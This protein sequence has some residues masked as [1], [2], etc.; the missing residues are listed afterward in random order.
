MARLV[1]HAASP[2]AA[3]PDMPSRNIPRRVADNL[4]FTG[5]EEWWEHPN[6]HKPPE[7]TERDPE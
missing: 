1:E 6:P 3:A 7:T 4:V 2:A 5:V